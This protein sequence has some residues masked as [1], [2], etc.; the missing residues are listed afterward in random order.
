MNRIAPFLAQHLRRPRLIEP[1]K[2]LAVEIVRF[3]KGIWACNNYERSFSVGG[4]FH[5][6]TLEQQEQ[7]RLFRQEKPLRSELNEKW[8]WEI[9]SKKS[10]SSQMRM[11]AVYL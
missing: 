11:K 1:W 2:Q 10:C 5:R 3:H 7:A 9:C 4:D 8:Q 6:A